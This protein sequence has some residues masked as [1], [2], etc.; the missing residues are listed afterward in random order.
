MH[1]LQRYLISIENA[2]SLGKSQGSTKHMHKVD[3]EKPEARDAKGVR[4]IKKPP[5][6]KDLLNNQVNK[7]G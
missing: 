4:G 5:M 7:K 2:I 3:K 1:Q 6:Q